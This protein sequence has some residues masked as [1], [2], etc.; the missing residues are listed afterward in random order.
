MKSINDYIQE[1]LISKDKRDWAHISD[2]GIRVDNMPSK[3][4]FQWPTKEDCSEWKTIEIKKPGKF[5][6]YYDKYHKCK[7]IASFG[8]ALETYILY[9]MY[10][11]MTPDII[12]KGF[13]TLKEAVKYALD[14]Y[15]ADDY[16]DHQ[17]FLDNVMSGKEKESDYVDATEFKMF[18]TPTKKRIK[19]YMSFV[20]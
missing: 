5:V 13:K 19:D 12:I 17:E 3:V 15:N 4:K 20:Y 9:Y 7:H 1:A 8:G 10:E 14:D 2:G 18:E 6:V 16:Y 11:D